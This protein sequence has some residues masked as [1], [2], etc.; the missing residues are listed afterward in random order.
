MDNNENTSLSTEK[1]EDEFVL[2]DFLFACLA[3]WKLFALSVAVCV[4]ATM[5]YLS[6]KS[7]VYM[8][9]AS[10]LMKEDN[11]RSASI[12]NTSGIFNNLGIGKSYMNTNDE[13][14]II[15][16]QTIALEVVQSL[17]LEVS[18][19]ISDRLKEITLYGKNL[20]IKVSFLEA[21]SMDNLSFEIQLEK[22]GKA[23]LSHFK[24]DFGDEVVNDEEAEMK[25]I[26]S[27]EGDTLLTP[28]G[29]IFLQKSNSFDKAFITS[30]ICVRKCNITSATERVQR[31][32]LATGREDGSSVVNIT[33]NGEHIG[34]LNDILNAVIKAYNKKW[35]EDRN[36]VA[37]NTSKFIN[38]RLKV[39]EKDLGLV[40]ED[41]SSYKSMNYVPNIGIATGMVMSQENSLD[42][43]IVSTNNK[44]HMAYFI[45]EYLSNVKNRNQLLPVNSGIGNEGIEGLI[46]DYNAQ[47]LQRNNIVSNSSE[48][49]PLI[50]DID[51]GLGTLREAILSSIDSEISTLKL[52]LSLQKKH[53]QKTAKKV[54]TN[55]KQQQYLLSVERQQ[56]VKE[57]LYLF[58]LQK[59]EENELNQ[60]FTAY[61]TRIVATP[62]GP[63]A[64]IA[65]NKKK[66]LLGALIVGLLIPIA[67]VYVRE[68]MN[69][70]VRSKSDIDKY[71]SLPYLG[72]IPQY[73]K[74]R[75]EQLKDS[76]LLVKE[77]NRDVFNEAFRVLRTN[78]EFVMQEKEKNVILLTSYNPG[79]GKSFISI[80]LSMSLAIKSKKVLLIDADLRHASVSNFYGK[81]KIGMANYLSKKTDNLE[82]III[83]E[84]NY[85]DYL[86]IIP[87]GKIPPNPTEL[88]FSEC[89]EE[90][91]A[92]LKKQYDY[93]I[94]DCP[95]LDIVADTSIIEKI[96]DRTFFVIRAGLLER[97]L[98]PQLEKEY[99][100]G[101]FKEMAVILNGTSGDG[102]RYGYRYGYRYRYGYKYGYKYGYNYGH[103]KS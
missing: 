50:K 71:L 56:K 6:S 30:T 69:T 46:N 24:G 79:S 38:E 39:I 80:N 58:L 83:K 35:V 45:K 91:I 48:S 100:K 60:A 25:T 20:P 85:P 49:N 62:N 8:R 67:F 44:I 97:G 1:V 99:K 5:L 94:I 43:T 12:G 88:L 90:M 72:E 59:R 102:G 40:D 14:A 11:R 55:P 82:S 37:L 10:V 81:P 73:H 84:E 27:Q 18:Y 54:K 68:E 41:I 26:L 76:T 75:K 34:M 15:N 63:G 78:I 9:R 16:S 86:H 36:Q 53:E 2:K 47:I 66:F 28:I 95:P 17:H 33:C 4:G 65:P 52:E 96:A 77:G 74:K 31:M 29:K 21:T 61:N 64:P 22:G 3:Q 92:T 87:V 57:A 101:T 98:L 32:Y 23:I 51:T 42:N 103:S 93:V 89:F 70:T 13:V 19:S 7:P